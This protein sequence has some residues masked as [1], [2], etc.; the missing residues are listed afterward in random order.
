MNKKELEIAESVV[1]IFTIAYNRPDFIY[2][3]YYSLCKFMSKNNKWVYTVFSDAEIDNNNN[4]HK[5]KNI[6][7]ELRIQH[8]RVPPYIHTIQAPS[9]RAGNALDW[10]LKYYA[11]NYNGLTLVLDSDMF[12]VK[13]LDLINFM[14]I[15]SDREE[16]YDMSGVI[17]TFTNAGYWIRYIWMA[18]FV[19]N[20]QTMKK[21]HPE[22][23]RFMN[24][25]DIE[26]FSTDAG[27]PMHYYLENHPELKIKPLKHMWSGTWSLSDL[28]GLGLSQ[29]FCDYLEK[30]KNDPEIAGI[31]EIVSNYF[32]HYRAGSNWNKLSEEM[33]ERRTEN[34][35]EYMETIVPPRLSR[36]YIVVVNDSDYDMMSTNF[37]MQNKVI[38]LVKR[39]DTKALISKYQYDIYVLKLLNH[40]SVSSDLIEELIAIHETMHDNKIVLRLDYLEPLKTN[41]D[42]NCES[43][44]V[45]EIEDNKDMQ[46][47][48]LFASSNRINSKIR[49]FAIDPKLW[50]MLFNNTKI[51]D[52][53]EKTINSLT[54]FTIKKQ[55]HYQIIVIGQIYDTNV[56]VQLVCKGDIFF[57]ELDAKEFSLGARLGV[58]KWDFYNKFETKISIG[59]RV[60]DNRDPLNVYVPL[61]LTYNIRK[62][63]LSCIKPLG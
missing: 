37:H 35:Q 33:M 20:G 26:N 39:S 14:R 17:Q 28:E 1:Q 3:Q 56:N 43:E 31:G 25:V 42:N 18:L 52:S 46:N 19:I 2:Y 6:C 7:K 62:A 59:F 5:I 32:Y 36:N 23:I 54:E 24:G 29:S 40:V 9:P 57:G 63:Y 22:Q 34:L 21:K 49:V 11:Y 4:D 60:T 10:V 47:S 58:I 50:Y 16:M 48:L 8:I 53:F 45:W 15:N 12:L 44:V 38:D 55:H 51:N 41:N 13:E 30:E 61:E 27:G